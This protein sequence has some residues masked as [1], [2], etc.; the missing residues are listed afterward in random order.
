MFYKLAS[1][2]INSNKKTN[3]ISEIFISQVDVEKENNFGKLF[4]CIEIKSNDKKKYEKIIAFIINKLYN[5]YYQNEKL[6]INPKIK[7]KTELI[8]EA[9]LTKINKN[10]FEFI[11][12]EKLKINFKKINITAGVIYENNIH[13]ANTGTNNV[14]LIYKNKKD[15]Y[16]ISNLTE[17]KKPN[18]TERNKLFDNV[19]SGEIPE[20]SSFVISNEALMEYLP[21]KT[22]IETVNS[23]PPIGAT[24]QIRNILQDINKYITFLAIIIKNTTNSKILD[25]K[26]INNK[27]AKDSI[28]NLNNTE[29][30]TKKLLSPRGIIDF[31]KI[32]DATKIFS[33]KENSKKIQI[34]DKIFSQ[35]RQNIFNKFTLFFTTLNKTIIILFQYLLKR[36]KKKEIEDIPQ[37]TNKKSNFK[38]KLLIIIFIL[39]FTL[40]TFNIS[41]KR[42]E[43]NE[44]EKKQEYTKLLENIEQKQNKAEAKLLF[45]DTQGAQELFKELE[46]LINSMPKETQEQKDNYQKIKNKFEESAEKI[47]KVTKLTNLKE[48]TGLKNINQNANP[49]NIILS[50]NK[51]NIYIADT[52]NK[53][54]YSFN[55][56]SNATTIS[57]EVQDN[58][59]LSSPSIYN[60]NYILY[61]GNNKITEFDTSSD[62]YTN[63][64]INLNLNNV[65]SAQINIYNN[66][67]YI[68]NKDENSLKRFT[69]QAES[70][71]SPY[72]WIQD[73]TDISGACGLAIDGNIYILKN[74]GE[75]LKFSNGT[76][77]D[78][79]LGPTD[80]SIS[81]PK[82]LKINSQESSFIYILED[83]RLLVFNKKGEFL[84]QYKSDQFT[85]LKDFIVDDSNQVMYFLNDD[86]I[87]SEKG[88]HY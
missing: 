87:L 83:N 66:K 4:I 74:N 34:K 80:P 12:E 68:L 27:S 78:F 53:T 42:I 59:F 55:I 1:L 73:K 9:S 84:V 26:E 70:F 85:N 10:F 64:N 16:K 6:L 86:K 72:D 49:Q 14:F 71:S 29:N 46:T 77:V 23:L 61:L 60:E 25:E 7:L 36:K 11:T 2:H 30:E 52:S 31:E 75:L 39:S 43:K 63:L 8:F 82:K 17:Q 81:N 21:S 28:I 5:N 57:T 35:K 47:R 41:I 67:L 56:K 44:E 76:K 3:S 22:L 32:S 13:F 69:K 65:N 45:S 20:K 79:T 24:E 62:K 58:D 38:K 19:I 33:N 40:L 88:K 48:L 54:I 51:E 50:N 18:S 37:L 15:E